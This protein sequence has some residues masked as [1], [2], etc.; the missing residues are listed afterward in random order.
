MDFNKDV[1]I[2]DFISFPPLNTDQSLLPYEEEIVLKEIKRI[3]EFAELAENKK[4]ALE[5]IEKY[6]KNAN[7]K[8]LL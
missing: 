7:Y 3:R 1:N 5:I 4:Q 8:V 6:L 2:Y